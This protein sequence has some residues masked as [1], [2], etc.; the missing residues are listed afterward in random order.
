MKK[1]LGKLQQG[2]VLLFQVNSLPNGKKKLLAKDKIVVME[3]EA[4]GHCHTIN[5]VG[6]KFWEI[7]SVQY[8]KLDEPTDIVHQEHGPITVDEGIW[9]IG[10]VREHDYFS[11][12]V[13]PVK[14]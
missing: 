9:M 8:L 1:K 10:R 3:G 7:D 12:M 5:S 4:T 6:S 13:A 2:D 14:D 11:K